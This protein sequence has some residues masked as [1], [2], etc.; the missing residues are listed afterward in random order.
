[1][2]IETE[3]NLVTPEFYASPRV[4]SRVEAFNG[5]VNI[6]VIQQWL[7]ICNH[8]GINCG[9]S[10]PQNIVFCLIDVRTRHV[11]QYVS[12]WRYVTLSVVWGKGVQTTYQRE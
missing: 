11:V 5:S 12:G 10:T 3:P 7:E 8:H 6:D 9:R 4:R 2:Q 1:M